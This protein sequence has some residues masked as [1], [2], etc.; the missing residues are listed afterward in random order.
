MLLIRAGAFYFGLTFAIGCVFG[1][2]RVLVLEPRI[3]MFL[4]ALAEAPFM[5]AAMAATARWTQRQCGVT[6]QSDAVGMGLIG[7]ALLL[8]VEIASTLL[9]RGVSLGAYLGYL[10]S[11]PGLV[12]LVLF[13]LFA[14][15]PVVVR[16]LIRD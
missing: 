5:I 2:I 8:T 4:A 15:M 11:P 13:I 9:L 3:G 7:L 6:A 16:T 1:P 10:V 12:A 14:G